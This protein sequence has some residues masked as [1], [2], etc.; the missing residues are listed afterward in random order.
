MKYV[1]TEN[2]NIKMTDG[3]PTVKDGDKE[4]GIDA[5]GAQTK[6]TT[7]TAESNDRRKKLGEANTSLEAF[8]GIEDPKAAIAALQKVGSMDKD[9]AAALDKMKLTVNTAWEAKEKEWGTEKE[10]L[11]SKL[12][13]ATVGAQFATSKVIKGTVLPADIAKATFGKHFNADGT[14]N[15]AAGN[16]INSIAKPGEPAG[17]DEA[18]EHILKAYPDRASIMKG[19]G[20]NGS[21]G[22]QTGDGQGGTS[23]KT[24]GQNIAEGLKA[25]GI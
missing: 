14:A 4:F 21:G 6:I 25:Q 1:L 9:Q 22:Y 13:D 10:T 24:A 3:K 11:N 5:I 7:I 17:F 15:D 12:F 8:K 18:M 16:Q 2:G 20:A 19:S 23:V